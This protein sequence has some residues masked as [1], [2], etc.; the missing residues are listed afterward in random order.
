MSTSLHT[1]SAHRAIPFTMV[2][3]PLFKLASLFVRHVSKY[4]AVSTPV[5][6]NPSEP[7]YP[8]SLADRECR[9]GSN[10]KPTTILSFAHSPP[11]MARRF[12]N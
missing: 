3:L 9:T 6:A 5:D 11:D 8:G 10:Y 4:G 7:K 2:P 12:T 1:P